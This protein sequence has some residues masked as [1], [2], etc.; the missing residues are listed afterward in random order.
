VFVLVGGEVGEAGASFGKLVG[1]VPA[2]R[3]PEAVRRLVE[4]YLA[5]RHAGERAHEFFIR[6]F[7]RAKE[8][9]APLEE[10]RLEDARPEDFVEPGS[11]EPF[12]P[13]SQEGECAA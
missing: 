7:D 10:L 3:A 11:T 9:V 8:V 4:L 1:R 2:R 6:A 13:D 12:R 5:G